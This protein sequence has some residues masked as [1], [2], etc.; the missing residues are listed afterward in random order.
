MFCCLHPKLSNA[1]VDQNIG[2]FHKL[3][4]ANNKIAYFKFEA[5]EEFGIMN[6]DFLHNLK[7]KPRIKIFPS[8]YTET[9]N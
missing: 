9:V 1:L 7:V 8:K 5:M 6:K 2:E 3:M 4:E